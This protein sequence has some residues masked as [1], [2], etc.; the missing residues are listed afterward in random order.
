VVKVG[1]RVKTTA[2]GVSIFVV[3]AIDG[4]SAWLQPVHD[5]RSR[6]AFHMPVARLVPVDEPRGQ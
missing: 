6:Y 2:E 1:D 4:D 5:V 3:T